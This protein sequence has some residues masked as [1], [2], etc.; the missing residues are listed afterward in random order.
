[1]PQKTPRGAPATR[2]VRHERAPE[3]QSAPATVC[4]AEKP[5]GEPSKVKVSR[6]I[7]EALRSKGIEVDGNGRAGDDGSDR[8]AGR[9]RQPDTGAFVAAGV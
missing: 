3:A 6:A 7:G 9:R 2:V 4:P 8:R 5:T 1:M